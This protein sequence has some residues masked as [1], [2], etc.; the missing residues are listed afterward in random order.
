MPFS[1]F[2][3]RSLPPML[4]ASL[5][6]M[7]CAATPTAPHPDK[8]HHTP[9]GF[10]NLPGGGDKPDFKSFLKWQWER[11]GRAPTPQDASKVPRVALEPAALEEKSRGWTMTWLGHASVHLQVDGLGILIDP[12]FSSRASPFESIG[13]KAHNAPPITL[14]NLPRVDL[15]LISHNHYDHLDEQTIRALARQPGGPPTFIVPLGVDRY[16]R[17]W[18]VTSIKTMDW[19]DR[20]TIERPLRAGEPLTLEMIPAHHWSR[21]TLT[22]TNQT[23]WAGFRLFTRD[24]TLVYTG[25]TGYSTIFKDMASK[26]P[27][28]DWLLVPV[29]CYEPRWFMGAQHVDPAEAQK[30]AQDLR[31]KNAMGVHWGVF[32]LCDEPVEQPLEDLR[33]A[34]AALPPESTRIQMWAI[35]E[36]RMLSQRPDP[37]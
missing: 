15:V 23:L 36:R 35:G 14:G 25:D 37:E 34:Q 31:A 7:G 30:I 17:G 2:P 19:F 26:W 4:A 12:V 21:R 5:V 13:P 11:L 29:G 32:R 24:M 6:L 20:Q 8:P 9:T 18:G 16:L 33:E 1:P 10:Q 3:P 28:V 22:D 27:P